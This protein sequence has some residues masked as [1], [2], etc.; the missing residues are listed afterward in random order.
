MVSRKLKSRKIQINASLGGTATTLAPSPR[1]PHDQ[2]G[3]CDLGSNGHDAIPPKAFKPSRSRAGP[4]Q[5]LTRARAPG[6]ARWGSRSFLK[7]NS[8][9]KRGPALHL[10]GSRGA[11]PPGPVPEH[12]FQ[13]GFPLFPVTYIVPRGG[14]RH[15]HRRLSCRANSLKNSPSQHSQ[16]ILRASF[17]SE[18]SLFRA[19]A[20]YSAEFWCFSVSHFGEG[21]VQI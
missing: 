5:T 6:P 10:V 3:P 12:G 19:Y 14:F 1:K 18:S 17:W 9:K 2:A 4:A 16:K 21:A 13:H 11:R 15:R 7:G 8:F 20:E